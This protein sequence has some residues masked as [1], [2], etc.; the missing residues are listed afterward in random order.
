MIDNVVI[1]DLD[2]DLD[3]IILSPVRANPEYAF[4]DQGLI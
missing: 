4:P 2:L 1:S 3:L